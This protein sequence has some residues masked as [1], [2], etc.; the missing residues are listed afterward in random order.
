MDLFEFARDFRGHEKY[1]RGIFKTKEELK[2][3]MRE[4]G[5]TKIYHVLSFGAGN[6]SSYMLE[7]HLKGNCKYQ[8]DF[9][10]WADTGGEPQF[11]HS[12][13]EWW[14]QRQKMYGNQTPFIITHHNRMK[15]GLEEM[16]FRY[17]LTDYQRF[18]MPVYFNNINE[19]TGVV[20]KGGIGKRQCTVDFKIIPVKQTVRKAI[21]KQH[22]LK[23]TQ[24]LPKNIGFIIDI[25]F[26]FDE[27]RRI[28]QYQS[29]Q[30][31][32]M[33]LAYPLVEEGITSDD[34][35]Q[36]L[37]ENR[38]PTKRSRCY[39]CPFNCDD[40][41]SGMDWMEIIETEPLSFLKACYFDEQIRKVQR[42]GNKVLRSIPYLHYSR[43][44]LKEVYK[45]KYNNL[46]QELNDEFCKWIDD[47]SEYMQQNYLKNTD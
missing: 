12:Q 27:I 28:H 11:I 16:L 42:E 26:S 47:W 37:T 4:K 2:K 18:Q 10:V 25:G 40:R 23:P 43:T 7:Q 31:K 21:L 20:E 38:F 9:I 44:P 32:Y 6:Q 41:D 45:N 14:Q 19:E 35:L 13:V 15:Y 1:M 30:Y 33:Y 34:T 22:G 24:R 3:E 29:P 8:Y 36:Y 17:I 46:M 5:M 39:F